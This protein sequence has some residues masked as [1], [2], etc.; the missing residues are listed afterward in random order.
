MGGGG[1]HDG[2]RGDYLSSGFQLKALRCQKKYKETND[3]FKTTKKIIIIIR[4]NIDRESGQYLSISIFRW[5]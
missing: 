5:V 4:D 2:I 1:C 3:S